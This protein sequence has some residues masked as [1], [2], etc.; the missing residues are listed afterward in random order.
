[1]SRSPAPRRPAGRPP[2][3]GASRSRRPQS[4]TR[5]LALGLA[6]AVALGATWF[7]SR[8]D[9][10]TP[11]AAPL[12]DLQMVLDAR[13]RILAAG[14]A[15]DDAEC[16]AFRILPERPDEPSRLD[17]LEK[18]NARCGGDPHTAPRLFGVEVDR[19]TGAM[20]D[21]AASPGRYVPLPR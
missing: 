11:P 10:S 17:V 5:L 12:T 9:G 2:P 19:A 7:L 20:R 14:L 16:L 3:P 15:R 1:M 21:D 18:H 4:P 13:A 6:L 8:P